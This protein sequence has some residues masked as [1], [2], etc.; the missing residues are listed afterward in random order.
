MLDKTSLGSNVVVLF[1][2][3]SFKN[4]T[5]II[6]R[7]EFM[8]DRNFDDRNLINDISSSIQIKYRIYNHYLHKILKFD[9]F[10]NKKVIYLLQMLKRRQTTK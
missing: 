7:N 6:I 3:I 4:I 1:L 9:Y 10:Y 2:T 8:T 5:N